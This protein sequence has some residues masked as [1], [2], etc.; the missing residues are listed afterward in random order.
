MLIK[1]IIKQLFPDS[2]LDNIKRAHARID[3]LLVRLCAQNGLMASLYYLVFNRRF[4]REHQ[5]VLIGRLNQPLQTLNPRNQTNAQLRR[6]IHRLEKGLIMRPR[7]D[8]F[9]R[10]YI[11]P[12]VKLYKDV[13]ARTNFCVAERQWAYDVLSR[14]FAAVT[15]VDIILEAYDLFYQIQRDSEHSSSPYPFK[16][17]PESDIDY[18]QIYTLFKRRR[19]VR[20]F[21][22]K[23]VEKE[24]IKQ[25]I[26]AASLAPSACNRQPYR[27]YV[28][29]D[30]ET[31]EQIANMAIGTAGF[32][33][34]FPC[35]IA[36]VGDLSCYPYERDRHLIY[37]DASLA[38]MQMML[39]LEVQGLSS[40]PI[41][42]P[43]ID[44]REISIAARLELEKYERVIMLMAVGYGDAEGE[45]PYSQKKPV[46]LLVREIDT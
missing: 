21:S 25:A 24:K 33:H 41:N 6:N 2:I 46:G 37:I 31:A 17:L 28:T 43:D 22:D 10:D 5:A 1:K 38:S 4:D 32:A 16:Q 8:T 11:L 45:I 15:K 35:L 34:N 9:A 36:V 39:A 14:Y 13:A 30:K 18:E 29:Y 23:V 40:C 19:S 12:T 27:F 3:K 26:T 44:D 20:W 42:W 7:R